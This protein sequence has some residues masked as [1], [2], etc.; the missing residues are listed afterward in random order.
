MFQRHNETLTQNIAQTVVYISDIHGGWVP[1]RTYARRPSWMTSS[2]ISRMTSSSILEC[3]S[4]QDGHC[5][6][7]HLWALPPTYATTRLF[8]HTPQYVLLANSDLRQI[9]VR[10]VHGEREIW[11]SGLNNLPVFSSTS[12]TRIVCFRKNCYSLS[13]LSSATT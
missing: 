11:K 4:I 2:S 8:T 7:E 6:C 1:R 9:K 10:R 13:T 12:I 5:T 3:Y